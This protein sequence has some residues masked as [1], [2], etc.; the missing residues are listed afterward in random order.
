[1]GNHLIQYRLPD[2]ARSSLSNKVQQRLQC[3]AVVVDAL[4]RCGGVE[5]GN[6]YL[7]NPVSAMPGVLH[8]H[9]LEATSIASASFL[10]V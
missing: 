6:G 3:R 9:G 7:K 4:L 2:E 1:M 10:Q 5:M 8:W